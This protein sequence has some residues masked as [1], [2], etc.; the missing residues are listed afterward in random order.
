VFI[1][2]IIQ[3]QYTTGPAIIIWSAVIAWIATIIFPFVW[4]NLF[5]VKIYEKFVEKYEN[6]KKIKNTPDKEKVKPFEEEID[7]CE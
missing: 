4:G 5:H 6:K 1:A 2:S 7:I 3:T